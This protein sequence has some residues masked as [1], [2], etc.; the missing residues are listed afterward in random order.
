MPSQETCRRLVARY[1]QMKYQVGRVCAVAGYDIYHEL[2]LLSKVAIV[3]D[4][5]ENG[6]MAIFCFDR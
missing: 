4:A 1:P 6:N 2:D 5:R 3:E